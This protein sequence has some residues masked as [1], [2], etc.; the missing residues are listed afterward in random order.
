MRIYLAGITPYIKLL[1][2]EFSKNP[3]VYVLESFYYLN[4]TTEA[5]IPLFKDFLLDSGAFTFFSAKNSVTDWESYVDKY[6]EFINKNSIKHFFELDIDSIVGEEKVAEL[7]KRLER[8][9][10]KQSIP[11]FHLSRGISEYKNLCSD[12]KYIAIGCSGKHDSRWT[13][14]HPDKLKQLVLYAKAKG[15]N[16]H[17]LGFTGLA[18]LKEIPFYSVD[19]TTWTTGNRFGYVFKFTGETITKFFKKPGQRLANLDKVAIN[20]FIE[21]CKF[22]KYMDYRY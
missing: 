1:Q 10:E 14:Q 11:V 13:R 4:D 7:R 12:Y 6:A 9:T 3:S 20:N 17:G 8:K 22:Q 15:V 18:G 16:V 19:S 5:C 2:S 21:W